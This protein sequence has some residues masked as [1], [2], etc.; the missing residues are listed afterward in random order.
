MRNTTTNTAP[1]AIVSDAAAFI[2]PVAPVVA[3]KPAKPARKPRA[4]KPAPEAVATPAVAAKPAKPAKPVAVVAAK[5]DADAEAKRCADLRALASTYYN[6]ASLAAH[7]S[8]PCKRDDYASRIT[9]PVQRIGGNGP[10]P[11]DESGLALILANAKRDG[12]FDPTTIN[13]DLGIASR[14]ASVGMLAYDKPSDTFAL[15]KPGR[16][17]AN[18]V[19]KRAA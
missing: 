13:L 7:Q 14:L 12:T 5:P 11:R 17:R 10:S 2:G 19:V 15:T 4:A 16:E 9:T 1:V 6:K 18:L 3:T 8:K